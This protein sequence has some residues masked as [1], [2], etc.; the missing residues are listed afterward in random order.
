MEF[1]LFLLEFDADHRAHGQEERAPT[2]IGFQRLERCEGNDW[3][4][5]EEPHQHHRSIAVGKNFPKFLILKKIDF[6]EI[7]EIVFSLDKKV[8]HLI[9]FP[10]VKWS[11]ERFSDLF[12]FR[13]FWFFEKKIK[14]T[15]KGHW[16]RNWMERMT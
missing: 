4:G 3:N 14:F 11:G 16:P 5:A 7:F 2:P 1:G 15:R 10:D 9:M 8:T 12:R 13:I 6:F